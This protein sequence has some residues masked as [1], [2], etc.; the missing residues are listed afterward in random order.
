MCHT[1]TGVFNNDGLVHVS[2]SVSITNSYLLSNNTT[3]QNSS[4]I[5]VAYSTSPGVVV[6]K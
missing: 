4:M 1:I 5:V 6:P 2:A 3:N